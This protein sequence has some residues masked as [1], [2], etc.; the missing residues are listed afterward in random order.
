MPR[1]TRDRTSKLD[2]LTRVVKKASMLKEAERALRH[3]GE[4]GRSPTTISSFIWLFEHVIVRFGDW[5]R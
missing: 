2:N 3:F 4:N 5:G 1:E